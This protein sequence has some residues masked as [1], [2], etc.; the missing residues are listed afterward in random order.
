MRKI[1]PVLG[2]IISLFFLLLALKDIHIENILSIIKKVN[3]S[4]LVVTL[5]IILAGLSQRAIRWGLILNPAR[6]EKF[7]NLFSVL[8]VGYFGN[9]VLPARMG[10]IFRIFALH[11]NYHYG[12]S[13]TLATIVLEKIFDVLILLFFFIIIISFAPLPIWIKNGGVLLGLGF[14][15]IMSFLFLFTHKKEKALKV[16]DFFAFSFSEKMVRRGRDILEK[17][18]EGLRIL[19][20]KKDLF[21]VIIFSF[22]I[23]ITEFF[24][25][26]AVI[27]SFNVQLG[28][29][30]VVFLSII[31]NLGMLIPSSPGYVGTFQFLCIMALKPFGVD[32]ETALSISIVL[33]ILALAVTTLIGL[34]CFWRENLKWSEAQTSELNN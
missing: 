12:K 33:H 8:M 6:R 21:I 3:F 22:S 32:K 31:L 34:L 7:Q 4:L 14:V 2:I 30:G 25:I 20:T 15:G 10:E 23:W 9:N 5:V 18:D 28:L 24:F 27:R 26:Y 17:F 11:K 19:K 29:T 1:K 13:R 16:L